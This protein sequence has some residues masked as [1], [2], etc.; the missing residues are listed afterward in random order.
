M[1]VGK[2]EG[3]CNGVQPLELKNRVKSLLTEKLLAY[4]EELWFME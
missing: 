2:I 3:C 1:S 4:Q